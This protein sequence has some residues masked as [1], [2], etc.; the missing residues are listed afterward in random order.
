M[1]IDGEA[2][3]ADLNVHIASH[4]AGRLYLDEFIL[5]VRSYEEINFAFAVAKGDPPV[6]WRHLMTPLQTFSH[7]KAV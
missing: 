4:L 1:V 5:P 7:S 6:Y 3:V 2:D